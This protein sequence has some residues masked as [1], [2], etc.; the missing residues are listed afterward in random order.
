MRPGL[1]EIVIYSD[2]TPLRQARTE[3]FRANGFG[4]DGGYDARWVKVKLGAVP[5]WFPNTDARRR[6]VRLHDLH[7]LATG[8]ETSLVGEAEIGAWELG[9]GCGHYTAAW[10]LNIAAVLLGLLVAPGRLWRAFL[11]GR[12]SETLYHL[13]FED[14][15]L[16]E[17]VGELR[18]RLRLWGPETQR[19]EPAADARFR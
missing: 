12:Q 7:H 9:G 1:S 14:R 16:D 13:G 3:Y 18:R 15:F 10:A 6:A 19:P 8:Y 2:S 17:T 5:V 11:R 4:E